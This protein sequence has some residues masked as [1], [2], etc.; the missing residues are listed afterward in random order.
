MSAV[1]ER[2]VLREG[3]EVRTDGPAGSLSEGVEVFDFNLT[4]TCNLV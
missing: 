4:P 3:S 2:M 1:G